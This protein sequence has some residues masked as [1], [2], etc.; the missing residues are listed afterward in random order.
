[1]SPS[2][3]AIP[4]SPRLLSLA[5]SVP[6]AVTYAVL[7]AIIAAFVL[8][9]SISNK[10]GYGIIVACLAG[11][12]V[13]WLFVRRR[14]RAFTSTEALWLVTWS[15]LWML[16]FE[17]AAYKTGWSVITY[18]DLVYSLPVA[19]RPF[20]MG[21]GFVLNVSALSFALRRHVVR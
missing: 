1:M 8:N 19:W 16:L 21:L 6:F 12:V 14:G 9:N 3:G 2:H 17:S 10:S 18:A 5:Y 7:A 20:V 4:S 15:S 13:R 11:Y